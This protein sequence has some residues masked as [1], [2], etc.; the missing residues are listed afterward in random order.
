MEAIHCR[1]EAIARRLEAIASRVI[2][3]SLDIQL[4]DAQLCP[5]SARYGVDSVFGPSQTGNP[6]AL[7]AEERRKRPCFIGLS[8]DWKRRSLILAMAT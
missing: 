4:P 2:T 3:S 8:R 6:A 5:F 1:L 7:V